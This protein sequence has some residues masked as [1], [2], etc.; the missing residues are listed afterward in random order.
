MRY[1]G[2]LTMTIIDVTKPRH[3]A[4]RKKRQDG[5]MMEKAHIRDTMNKDN[6]FG[7]ISNH[8]NA[9]NPGTNVQEPNLGTGSDSG[10]SDLIHSLFRKNVKPLT[11]SATTLDRSMKTSVNKY[12]E[13]E[14]LVPELINRVKS[15]ARA[16]DVIAE[17]T[18]D[19]PSFSKGEVILAT[20][21]DKDHTHW[22]DIVSLIFHGFGYITQDIGDNRSIDQV[23]Q[24]VKSEEP[25]I[26]CIA[27]PSISTYPDGQPAYRT[28]AKPIIKKALKQLSEKGC[29]KDLKIM[30]AGPIPGIESVDALDSDFYCQNMY[31]T[32]DAIGQLSLSV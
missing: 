10:I 22:K 15:I 4:I 31:Q 26:L 7:K 16:R 2:Y 19:D 28:S 14:L 25:D 24:T 9:I 8:I 27:M 1:F 29:R 32:I 23:V 11:I 6:L 18:A 5:H 20:I 17:F 13:N 21:E 3:M 30:V 12:L